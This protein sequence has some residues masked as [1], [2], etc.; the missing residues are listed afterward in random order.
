MYS[1]IDTHAHIYL[2]KFDEDI[3]ETLSKAKAKG[4]QKIFMPN[5][6]SSSIDKMLHLEKEYEDFCVPMMGIHPC[7]INNNYEQE[8]EVASK[9]L[10]K[11]K[12]CAVGEIGIDLYW[13]KTHKAEQIIAFE[14][15]IQWAK[16]LNVPIVIHCRESIDLT[17][18]IVSK[19][20]GSNL[21]GVFHCFTGTIDQATKITEMGFLLG[22]GGVSTFKNGGLDKVLPEIAL[23]NLVLETDSPYLAPTPYRGKRNEPSYLYIVAE[24]LAEIKFCSMKDLAEITTHNSLNLFD[25]EQ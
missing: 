15:Q 16:E 5:I 13:D 17:I 10:H 6:D 14:T 12:F 20:A 4:I 2:S 24:R 22:I 11:G 25:H 8:L 18:D 23:E 1:L 9:W 19:H 3:D 21:R 7:Y